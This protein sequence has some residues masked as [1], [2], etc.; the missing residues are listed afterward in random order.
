MLLSY[1]HQ[2][3]LHCHDLLGHI[4]RHDSYI[5][6]LINDVFKNP[7]VPSC[8]AHDEV[9]VGVGVALHVAV[10]IDERKVVVLLV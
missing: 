7:L 4:G 1:L 3:R 2:G 5:R 8:G 6:P 9:A 10:G